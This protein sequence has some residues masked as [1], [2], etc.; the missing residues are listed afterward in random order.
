[1]V[2]HGMVSITMIVLLLFQLTRFMMNVCGGKNIFVNTDLHITTIKTY[3][4]RRHKT[5]KKKQSGR[6]P[7][8]RTKADNVEITLH[9]ASVADR[10]DT[11]CPTSP[12]PV[13]EKLYEQPRQPS[14][15]L[16]HLSAA[17]CCTNNRFDKHRSIIKSHYWTLDSYSIPYQP[18][19]IIYF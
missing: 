9:K 7:N 18:N 2:F 8:K 11:G 13:H 14:L 10:T 1:M 15:A 6:C 5:K 19:L 3:E 4:E 17:V 12:D 16:A